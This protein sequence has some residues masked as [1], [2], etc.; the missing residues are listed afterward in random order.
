M[1]AAFKAA[2]TFT[3]GTGS[4]TP[5]YPTSTNA[6]VAGDIALL[7][8]SSENETISLTTANG[9]VEVGAQANK[10]AGTAATD[11]ATRLAVYW[12]RCVGSDSA[13]VIADSGNNTEGQ[14]FLF[15]GCRNNGNPW[16]V[17]AEGNDSAANDTS[18]SIPGTST[19]VA[20]TLIVA[21]CSTSNNANSTTEFSGWTNSNLTS[22]TEQAD[23]SDT[24]GLGGGFGVATGNWA[25]IGNYGATT[26]T[27]AHTSFKGTMS[28]A[29]APEV[30]PTVAL[31]TPADA[32]TVST[33]TP[34]LNF[35]G[36]DINGDTVEYNVQVDTVNTFDSTQVGFD[37]KYVD[38]DLQSAGSPTDNLFLDV[39]SGSFSGTTLGTSDAVSA[40]GI[41]NGSN[42]KRFTFSTPVTL[43]ASTKYYL[44]LRRSGARDTTNFISWRYSIGSVYSGGGGAAN[45]SGTWGSESATNDTYF[46]VYDTS[47]VAQITQ[48]S[49]GNSGSYSAQGGTGTNQECGQS[50]TIATT[51]PTINKVST[52]DAG[53]T[54]G[55]PFTSGVAKDYTVQTALGNGTYYWRVRAIDPSGS[56]TYGAWSS[57]TRSFV[58]SAGFIYSS[59]ESMGRG[60]GRGMGPS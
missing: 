59:L 51:A 15:S 43:G 35:T 33:S 29:L 53:F 25:S 40:V 14:I 42:I 19:T 1:A 27:L 11:P 26:V 7:L 5:P 6:P 20:N 49:S 37:L 16:D 10:A 12:K 17:F 23:N 48:T 56:N 4:I 54:A 8:V 22:L 24:S 50:F 39:R 38:A 3:A 55:H 30:S 41:T 44:V 13:P 46:I 58:V 52:A 34:T 9:F 28:I 2:G 32:G 45:N 18:G 36:T 57:P 31:N 47:T 60:M 21:I